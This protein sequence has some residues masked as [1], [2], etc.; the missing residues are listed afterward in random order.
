MSKVMN[1]SFE[2]PT[3]AA[4]VARTAAV[5]ANNRK[6][7][8]SAKVELVEKIKAYNS[9]N[10]ALIP[11]FKPL[12][13]NGNI[14]ALTKRINKNIVLASGGSLLVID[15]RSS[16]RSSSSSSSSSSAGGGGVI[17]TTS[18]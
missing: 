3:A 7:A 18:S 8:A 2:D 10:K 16:S 17:T 12:S 11:N 6:A 9:S 5:L 14:D 1:A 15:G 13:E 4:E